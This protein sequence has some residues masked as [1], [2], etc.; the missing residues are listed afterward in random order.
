MHEKPT[1]TSAQ[2]EDQVLMSSHWYEQGDVNLN[3]PVAV[4]NQ[5]DTKNKPTLTASLVFANRQNVNL[6]TKYI[7]EHKKSVRTIIS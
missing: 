4:E 6:A 5:E 3:V 7:H 2:P 1:G